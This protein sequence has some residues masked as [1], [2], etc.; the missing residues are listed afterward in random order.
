MV[1]VR[2]EQQEEHSISYEVNVVPNWCVQM[3][4]VSGDKVGTDWLE[5]IAPLEG[6]GLNPG[7][8][9]IIKVTTGNT[10][11]VTVDLGKEKGRAELKE[12]PEEDDPVGA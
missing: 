3:I 5:E 7:Q 4:G 12:I 2:C 1:K 8:F 10:S 6:D 11:H 9:D